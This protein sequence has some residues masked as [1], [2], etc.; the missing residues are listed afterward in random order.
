MYGFGPWKWVIVLIIVLMLFG[1]K[2]IPEIMDGLGKGLRT[3]KKVL[4][5][6]DRPVNASDESRRTD[7][8]H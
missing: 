2:R 1:G 6:E 7:E 4:E 3:F 5:G 8:K